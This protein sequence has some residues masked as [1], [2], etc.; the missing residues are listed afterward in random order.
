MVTSAF[1][2]YGEQLASDYLVAQGYK[3]IETKYVN[4]I[5]E[6][7]IVARDGVA[8]CFIEV[9]ARQGDRLGHP[10]E[11]VTVFKQNKLRRVAQWYLAQ[12]KIAFDRVLRFDVVSVLVDES[13]VPQIEL[14]K[15]A[16]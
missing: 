12:H 5:G 14:I 15:N 4:K 7:D 13:F 2:D 9:K 1:G 16:F 8:L 11:A 6:I 3:I 10:L